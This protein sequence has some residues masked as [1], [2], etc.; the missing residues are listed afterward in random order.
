MK[1]ITRI[2]LAL[3]TLTATAAGGCSKAPAATASTL[4]GSVAQASFPKAVSAITVKSSSGKT[5]SVAVAA[6]GKFSVR[7]EKGA[8]YQLFLGPDGK[9]IPSFSRAARAAWRRR[10]T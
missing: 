10:S 4:V 3:T 1:R 7:L 6:D 9:S 5:S 8:K 2:L